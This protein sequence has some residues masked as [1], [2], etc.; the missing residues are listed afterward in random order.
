VFAVAAAGLDAVALS[1]VLELVRGEGF[2]QLRKEI[3]EEARRPVPRL[4]GHVWI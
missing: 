2:G 3:M 4:D 1:E